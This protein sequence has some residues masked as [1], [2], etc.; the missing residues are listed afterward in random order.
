MFDSNSI[1]I[2]EL[3]STWF[4]V[5]DLSVQKN[6]QYNVYKTLIN[7]FIYRNDNQDYQSNYWHTINGEYI[8]IDSIEFQ[9]SKYLTKIF[10]N[11]YD[12]KL[13]FR[14]AQ[15]LS[16]TSYDTLLVNRLMKYYDKYQL[17]EG[18]GIFKL[19]R[20][21]YTINTIT[22]PSSTYEKVEYIKGFES[23]LKRYKVK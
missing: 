17:V 23:L 22:E 14:K 20:D 15:K 18:I 3:E 11:K 1:V 5:I 9:G 10:S 2:P 19:Q 8:Y 13:E 12:S 4:P 21:S 6:V 7:N 16:E